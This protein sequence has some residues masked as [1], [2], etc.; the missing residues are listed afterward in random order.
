[1][2]NTITVD[3]FYAHL[4]E[5]KASGQGGFAVYFII[6]GELYNVGDK[7]NEVSCIGLSDNSAKAV[8]IFTNKP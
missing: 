5:L 3:Q 7:S 2:D 6:N 8:K 4:E 1:M